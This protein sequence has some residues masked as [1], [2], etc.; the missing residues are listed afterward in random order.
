MAVSG[1]G[2]ELTLTLRDPVTRQSIA[3]IITVDEQELAEIYVDRRAFYDYADQIIERF[4]FP[5]RPLLLAEE[6]APE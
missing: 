6:R 4:L 3:E 5:V 2:S 1:S